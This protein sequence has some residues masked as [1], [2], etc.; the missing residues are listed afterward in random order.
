MPSEVTNLVEQYKR[1]PRTDLLEQIYRKME[2]LIRS[3]VAKYYASGLPPEVL[4]TQ[5]KVYL[6]QAIDAYQI[7]K[8]SFESFAQKYMQQMYRFVNQYQH[9]VRLPE[10]YKN[11]Y[12]KFET[13]YNQLET[14]LDRQP[15]IEELRSLTN[16][17]TK[18][19]KTFMRRQVVPL[20]EGWIEAFGNQSLKLKEGLVAVGS[21]YGNTVKSI[22]EDIVYKDM[23]ITDALKKRNLD[24][25]TYYPKIK[26]ALDDLILYV[27][28]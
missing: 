16:L 15:T 24:Y 12:A 26:K 23:S 10:N 1:S 6:K 22:V 18:T 3:T 21:R 8:G 7:G 17:N 25:N 14:E 4:E 5:A 2:P 11:Q 9:P 13:V 19:L 27:Q 28:Q 20:E